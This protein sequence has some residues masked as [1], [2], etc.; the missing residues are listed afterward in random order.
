MTLREIQT[1]GI[2]GAGTLGWKIGLQAAI[3]GFEVL[4]FD[5]S[6]E[7]LERSTNFQ[8]QLCKRLVRTGILSED[9]SAEALERIS[10]TTDQSAFASKV[11]F[12]SESVTEELELKRKVWESFSGKWKEHVVLTTNT[13]YLL[14][15]QMVDVVGDPE[16]FCAFHFHD[17]FDARVVDVM[18]HPNT[19]EKVI[20]FL[21]D[22]GRKLNQIPVHVEHETS[23]YLFNAML[24]AYLGAAGNLLARGKA[25]V[26][27]IDRSWMGNMSTAIGPFGMMDVVG[28][29]TVD[30]ILRVR[31]DRQSIAFREVITP[32][33][34]KGKLGVKSGEGFYSYPKPS[35]ANPEFLL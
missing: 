3:S 7:Q 34:S 29:D 4:M 27:A 10:I 1:F 32:Y 16:R 18:G 12:V 2:L 6:N 21:I 23:G 22:L 30:H 17:V 33:V 11:D 8:A 15:S 9:D 19:S 26:E 28:L 5:I 24:M 14:P 13:S 31:T 35:Y 20:A 25:T